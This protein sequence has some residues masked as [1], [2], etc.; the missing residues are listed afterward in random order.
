M[1]Q[2]TLGDDLRDR[3]MA[4]ATSSTPP[5]I[6]QWVDAAIYVCRQRY[7]MFTSDHVRDYLELRYGCNPDNIG[8]VI[9]ARMNAAG[10]RR[11]ITATGM[12]TKSSRPEAHRRRL[13]IWRGQP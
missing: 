8:R 3:G 4:A 11:E 10:R 9:G 6:T 2:L 13:L 12:T 5:E 1:D 7:P